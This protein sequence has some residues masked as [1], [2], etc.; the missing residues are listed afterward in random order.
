MICIFVE[1]ISTI[2]LAYCF[3]RNEVGST[4]WLVYLFFPM[5]VAVIWTDNSIIY[6]VVD[7]KVWAYIGKYT[8]AIYLSHMFVVTLFSKFFVQYNSDIFIYGSVVVVSVMF[9]MMFY[10][11]E[12]WIRRGLKLFVERNLTVD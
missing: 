4:D 12:F 5:L 9:G 8:Y 10:Y 7:N 6:N 3:S 2:G 1:L 11:V